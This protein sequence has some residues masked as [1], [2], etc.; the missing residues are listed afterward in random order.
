M[1]LAFVDRGQDYLHIEIFSA[2][3]HGQVKPLCSN[4]EGEQGRARC[5]R[6]SFDG[7][8]T[9]ICVFA[10]TRRMK[11]VLLCKS[12][13][14]LEDVRDDDGLYREEMYGDFVQ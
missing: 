11:N 1:V 8:Q 5:A 2:S 7:R 14:I 12:I 9:F 4:G 10:A 6:R 13:C 3:W